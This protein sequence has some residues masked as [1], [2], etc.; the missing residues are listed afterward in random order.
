MAV[1]VSINVFGD[2]F[3]VRRIQAMRYR[4]RNME[5]VLH[6]IADLWEDWIENQFETQGARGG[7]PWE[8]LRT[9]TILNRGSARPILIHSGDMFDSMGPD[10]IVVDDDS[11][12]IHWA[13]GQEHK[14]AAHQYGFH[15]VLADRD[16]P[17]R[18]PVVFTALDK[19]RM[20]EMVKDFLVAGE[21]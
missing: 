19:A 10:N 7:T 3:W 5:P 15:N 13:P 20:R 2:D 8:K 14:A 9:A 18:P 11:I 12:R 4:S 21:R 16:V 17:A 1:K 6:D